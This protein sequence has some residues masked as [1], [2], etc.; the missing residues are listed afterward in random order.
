ARPCAWCDAQTARSAIWTSLRSSTPARRTTRTSRRRAATPTGPSLGDVFLGDLQ[1][2]EERVVAGERRGLP[3][4][5]QLEVGPE[6]AVDAVDR[7][8]LAGVVVLLVDG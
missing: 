3:A 7:D 2:V 4:P 8:E 1:P 5:G 6:A